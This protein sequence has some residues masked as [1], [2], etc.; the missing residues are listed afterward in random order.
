MKNEVFELH[1]NVGPKDFPL[2]YRFDVEEGRTFVYLLQSSSI[3]FTVPVL[4]GI[5]EKHNKRGWTIT[6]YSLAPKPITIFLSN[7]EF[8][9]VNV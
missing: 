3:K 1:Q 9:R 8:T 4:M 6:G 2:I 5:V 7:T